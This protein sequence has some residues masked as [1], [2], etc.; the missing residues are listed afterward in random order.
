MK[1]KLFL[2]TFFVSGILSAQVSFDAKVSK[3]QLGINERLRVDFTMNTDGD[4]FEPPSFQNF[5]VVGGPSQSINNS[6]INGTRSFSKSY[7][8]FL[9]PKKRGDFT[10]GQATIEIDGKIY[11]TLPIKITVTAAIDKPKDP[12]DPDYIASEKIHLVAEVSNTNPYLNE[13]ITVVYKLYV[14]Q[15]TGVRNWREIDNP[16]YGDFWSQNIDVK[17]VNIQNGTYKGEEYRYV[18]LRKTVLYPQKTGKLTIEPLPL[19]VTVEVPSQRRDVFGRSFMSTVNRTVAS[20]N[21][22]INVKPLPENGKPEDFS[23]AVGSF[24]FKLTTNKQTLKATEALEL[25]VSVSG[26]GNLKLFRLPKLV[27]PSALEV[28]EPEHSE[29]VKTRTSGMQGSIS[30]TYTVVPNYQGSYPIPN[31]SF[32]YFDLKTKRYK[33]LTSE[34]LIIEVNEGPVSANNNTSG[35]VTEN[36]ITQNLNQFSSFKTTTTLLP[37]QSKPFFNSNLFWLL[38]L[39]PFLLIPL[40]MLLVRNRMTRALDVSGNKIRKTNRLARKYLSAAKK[41]LGK[42]E[43]FYNALERALHNYLKS[44]LRLETSEF[45]KEKIEELLGDKSVNSDT[46]EGFMSL[47]TSCELARYTPLSTVDMQNDYG[48]AASVIN[49]LDKQLN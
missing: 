7:S 4:D 8:Y 28:Y 21:R 40:I 24:N 23:G 26:K 47:L 27:L 39:A 43:Q 20:G 37:I 19:D 25:K 45:N 12:N 32:S 16:R 33:T 49:A 13:A 1:L 15:N 44:K 6:W 31:V 42:K 46:L 2:L 48:K 14:A 10:I 38:L 34:R 35:V 3:K 22:T 36:V 17:S 5:T 30:D 29:N 11:K 18:I 9:A 41:S